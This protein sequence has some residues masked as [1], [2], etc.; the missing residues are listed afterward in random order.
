MKEHIPWALCFTFPLRYK[1]KWPIIFN[2]YDYVD[3]KRL[4]EYV[5][6]RFHYD[7][8]DI[9]ALMTM[10]MIVMS[11][12]IYKQ[13]LGVVTQRSSSSSLLPSPQLPPTCRWV[14]T[15]VADYIVW[16]QYVKVYQ[17]FCS[18]WLLIAH[19]MEPMHKMDAQIPP[20]P[21]PSTKA[22]NEDNSR[23]LTPWV[24]IS[25]NFRI[26]ESYAV[27]YAFRAIFRYSSPV[28]FF[29]PRITDFWLKEVSSY[30]KFTSF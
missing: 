28:F 16:D 30:S 2:Y 11:L 3:N 29:L 27:F 14:A 22:S 13:A 15:A 4:Y 17:Q 10:L 26:P 24:L 7:M 23:K 12:Y 18:V 25:G 9:N 5:F 8:S 20:P 19:K 6:W 1:H 21:P